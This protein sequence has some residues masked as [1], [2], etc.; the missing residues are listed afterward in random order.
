MKKLYISSGVNDKY[1][2]SET[3]IE[4]LEGKTFDSYNTL[5]D[6]FKNENKEIRRMKARELTVITVGMS[7]EKMKRLEEDLIEAGFKNFRGVTKE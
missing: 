4:H 1:S 3:R 5:M 6:Y 7:T 2:V